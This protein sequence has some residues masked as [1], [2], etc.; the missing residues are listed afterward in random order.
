[1]KF[2]FKLLAAAA[3]L[4][5]STAPAFAAINTSTTPSLLFVAYDGS[6][7]TA[8]TY[9]RILGPLDSIG[10]NNVAFNAPVNSIFTSQ[11]TNTVAGV[12]TTVA[13]SNIY[14]NVF[15]L[16]NANTSAPAV[17]LTGSLSDQLGQSLAKSDVTAIAGILTGSLGGL[18]QLDLAANGYAKANGEYT[19]AN[20][21]SDQ[22]NGN[23]LANNFSFSLP[24][25]GTGV[26]TSQNLLKVGVVGN[27][28]SVSQLFT[29]AALS[30]FN[31]NAAGGYFTLTDAQGDVTWT[32]Q[33]A[34]AAVPLPAAA[35]LFGP[36]LL[37]LLGVGRKRKSA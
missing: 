14:W 9:V 35:L 8:D 22:T 20:N 4:A 3:V 25:S 7:N 12:T 2:K 19:G 26:G 18:T 36:G 24:T 37:T 34:V 21:V 27:G 28:A 17:Y 13:P 32:G 1:M 23:T 15:A 31:G 30:A 29:N 10:T 6:G 11:F 16:N 5:M 33:A